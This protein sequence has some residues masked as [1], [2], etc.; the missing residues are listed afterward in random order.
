MKMRTINVNIGDAGW[1]DGRLAMCFKDAE[2]KRVG[3][4]PNVFHAAGT[5][6]WKICER[7]YKVPE[8][9]VVLEITPANFGVSGRVEFQDIKITVSAKK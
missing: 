8:G 9:A 5:T 2:G 1:K 6:D 4:W 3:E 7:E